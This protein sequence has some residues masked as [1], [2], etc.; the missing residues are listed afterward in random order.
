MPVVRNDSTGPLQLSGKYANASYL[1]P[2]EVRYLTDDE[3]EKIHWNQRGTGKL[4]SISPSETTSENLKIKFD[5]Y[6]PN[7]AEYEV[8]Y[9]AYGR[10]EALSTDQVWTIRRH[11]YA[12]FGS[13]ALL[14]EIQI[15]E[16]VAWSDR[17]ILPW[18]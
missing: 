2:G 16:N 17:A 14:T 1:Q 15:L 8:R 12:M 11:S 6:Q 10:P 7:A 18:T 9:I 5:Y 3:Y 4:V 13:T